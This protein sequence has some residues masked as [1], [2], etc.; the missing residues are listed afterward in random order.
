VPTFRHAPRRVGTFLD[1][2]FL[3]FF[4]DEEA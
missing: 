1:V 3:G 2:F 4:F